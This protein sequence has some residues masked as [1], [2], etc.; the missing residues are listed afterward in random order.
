MNMNK[1]KNK[2][3]KLPSEVSNRN[4]VVMAARQRKGGHMR[5]KNDRRKA[6]RERREL[7]DSY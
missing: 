3:V 5:H 4:P 7:R 1:N 2:T 6:D